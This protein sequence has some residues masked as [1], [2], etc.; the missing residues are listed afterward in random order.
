V[1]ITL[2]KAAVNFVIIG[3]Q[4]LEFRPKEYQGKN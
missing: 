4:K 1:E 3:K 2:N